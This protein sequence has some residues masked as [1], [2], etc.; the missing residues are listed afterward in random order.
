[1]ALRKDIVSHYETIVEVNG[2]LKK[3]E[4][5]FLHAK[6]IWNGLMMKE[7]DK[8]YKLFNFSLLTVEICNQHVTKS[9]KAPTL[10]ENKAKTVH[11]KAA[12]QSEKQINILCKS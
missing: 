12:C 2:W 9:E 4:Y 1:M 10:K 5:A 11:H 6:N 8:C 7:F 3:K